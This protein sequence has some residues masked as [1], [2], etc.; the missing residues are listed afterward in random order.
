MVVFAAAGDFLGAVDLF[1]DD[2]AGEK[3]WE[4]QGREGPNE[5]RAGADA[6]VFD[7]GG[8]GGRGFLTA[9]Y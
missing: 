4:D 6:I 1:G 3:V 9:T 5:I 2:Q 8:V 7:E